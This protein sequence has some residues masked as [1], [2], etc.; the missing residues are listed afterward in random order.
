MD[1]CCPDFPGLCVVIKREYVIR[2]ARP[3]W[4][5]GRFR[6]NLKAY[7]KD[8]DSPGNNRISTNNI[9]GGVESMGIVFEVARS[10]I[11]ARELG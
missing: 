9:E 6:G 8:L 3:R 11:S 2:N 5:G 1:R 10:R 4:E 7:E